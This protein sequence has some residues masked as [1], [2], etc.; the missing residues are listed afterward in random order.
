[1]LLA[2]VWTGH[3]DIKYIFILYTVG[4]LNFMHAYDENMR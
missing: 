4:L 3:W 2:E 1:M